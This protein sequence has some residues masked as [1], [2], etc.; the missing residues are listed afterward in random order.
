MLAVFGGPA[1]VASFFSITHGAGNGMIT[2]AK[3]TLPLA[4]FGAI[5][6]GHRQGLLSVL[7]RGMQAIAPFTFGVVLEAHGPRV[8]LALSVT[9]SVAA[10][11]ALVALRK[12]QNA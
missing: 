11:A 7:G 1:F 8:A 4:I 9:L 3:G 5:G 2:I 12:P 10:L 6:Y